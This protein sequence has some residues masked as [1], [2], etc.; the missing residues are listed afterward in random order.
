MRFVAAKGEGQQ[1]AAMVFRVRDLVVR[2]RTQTIN[3]IRGHL[4]KFGLVAAQGFFHAGKL[5][6]AIE[7]RDAAIP[8]AA[9]TPRSMCP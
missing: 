7:D 5:V 1:A 2:Q 4:A 8:E 6:V 3:A 9:R